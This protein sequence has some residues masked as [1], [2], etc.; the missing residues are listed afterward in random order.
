MIEIK[1]IT[2]VKQTVRSNESMQWKFSQGPNQYHCYPPCGIV[3]SADAIWEEDKD[4]CCKLVRKGA[5]SQQ[6][7]C[8]AARSMQKIP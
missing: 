6:I 8:N 1:G 3:D 7:R 5:S 2:E 4:V